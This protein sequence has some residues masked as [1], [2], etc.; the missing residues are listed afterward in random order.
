MR[1]SQYISVTDKLFDMAD[2]AKHDHCSFALAVVL[3]HMV[4]RGMM[5]RVLYHRAAIAIQKRYR[6][7]KN[8][9]KK[10][11]MVGPAITIQRFWRGLRDALLVMRRDDAAFKIQQSYKAWC[12][13]R[14][15]SKLLKST[16]NIQR[17]WLGAV[18]RRWL[19]E[20][21]AA[22]I[23][24]QKFAR[25]LQIRSVLDK[26]GRELARQYRARFSDLMKQKSSMPEATYL[27]KTA[28]LSGRMRKEMHDLRFRNIDNKRMAT[29]FTTLRSRHTRASDKEKKL[30]M[31]GAIQPVRLSV[32]EPMVC[33]L[34]RLEP[35][36]GARYGSRNSRVL[37]Q[38]MAARK[39]LDR[40]MPK[41]VK[42]EPHVTA[43][44]GRAAIL[45]RRLAKK[46]KEVRQIAETKGP[47]NTAMFN[48]WAARQFA[49]K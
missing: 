37:V 15:A 12:W 23:F 39:K 48:A 32:F 22:A 29:T 7:L 41:T 10:A 30:R 27:A 6:Y 19:N 44:R 18:H 2:R 16:L 9:G 45:A 43:R 31:R 4:L 36:S 35:P 20:C 28:A 1:Q 38:A 14:R 33:A 49:V 26:Q 17:L 40:T 34:A 25:G 8:K 11:N 46:P 42:F 21:H 5:L 47:I 24:I 3:Y 13:N